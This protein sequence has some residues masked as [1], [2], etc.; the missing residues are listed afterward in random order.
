M[1]MFDQTV[2]EISMFNSLYEL[3]LINMDYFSRS[4][5]SNRIMDEM[6]SAISISFS[7][8]LRTENDSAIF[9]S[10]NLGRIQYQ[11]CTIKYAQTVFVCKCDAQRFDDS[12]QRSILKERE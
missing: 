3:G 10:V 5:S 6:K 12:T 9:L 2:F 11:Y 4:S 8:R 7:C 1:K